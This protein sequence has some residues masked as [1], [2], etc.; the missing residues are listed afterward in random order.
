MRIGKFALLLAAVPYAAAAQQKGPDQQGKAGRT[1]PATAQGEEDEGDDIVV[2]GARNL[3]GAVIGNVEPE[4]QLGPAEIRSFG[5]NSVAELLAALAPQTRSGRGDGAPVVL[6]NGRRV[7]GFS[8]IRDLPTEAILRVDI[9]PEE[10]ALKHGYSADQRVVNFVL[11]PRFRAITA[12]L[13]AQV[14]TDGGRAGPNAEVDLLRINRQGRI[15]L[16]LGYSE[17]SALTESERGVVSAA[18]PFA[19][20]GNV[21][22]LGGQEIDPALSALAGTPATIAGVPALAAS[23]VPTLADFAETAGRANNTDPAPFRTLLPATHNFDANLVYSRTVFSNV[24]ATVNAR[25]STSDSQAQLGLASAA[26]VL[27][28]GNPFSPFGRDVVVERAFSGEFGPLTQRNNQINAHAGATLNGNV[29]KWQ[30][31]LIGN[32]DRN[33]S[34]TFTDTG[35]DLSQFQARL[36]A[37]Y[38]AANP[39]GQVTPADV[40]VN[41]ATLARSTSTNAGVDALVNGTLV[42]LPAGGV[43]VSVRTSASTIGFDSATTRNLV[44]TPASVSRGIVNGQVNVDVPITSRAK[45]VLGAIGSVSANFNY[46]LDHFSDFG[47]LRTL[48]YGLTWVPIVP[49]R[50]LGS[51]T[52]RTGAPSP[53]QLGNPQ[54]TTPNVRVFDFSRGENALV[55]TISGGNPLLEAQRSRTRKLELSVKPWAARDINFVTNYVDVRVDNAIANFPTTTAAIEAAFPDRFVRNAAGQLLRIDV[56]PVNLAQTSRSELRWGINFSAPIKSKIQKQL[57]AFRAGQG[58]N[59]FAGLVPAGGRAPG[60]AGAAGDG[61]PGGGFGGPGGGGFGGR[62][63]AAAA[64]GRVQFAVYHTLRLSELTQ[65]RDTLPRL[66]LLDGDTL[67]GAG[68]PSRHQIEVQTGY[69]NNGIGARISANWESGT[70]VRG[71]TAAVPNDL[72]FGSIGTANFRLFADLGQRLEFVKKHRWARGVRILIAVDNLFNTRQQVTDSSGATPVNFQPAFRDPLG[73]TVRLSFRKLLF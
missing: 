64:G 26:L 19:I 5:V 69:N 39:F 48:G 55:T 45:K 71:G 20:G 59:P 36:S 44:T 23:G 32:Y 21:A 35:L 3:P 29:G 66:D 51:I 6:V 50:L 70:L 17:N 54:I 27:P 56:R 18:S 38:P 72:R 11:R 65:V 31:S 10:V 60:A 42:K 28:Q 7:S 30:W 68:G 40:S 62:G 34:E 24:G 14:A 15:S 13:E 22:G 1:T 12:E 4:N 41:P 16:H 52:E 57:E 2:Q 58:P 49:V 43:S 61:R 25:L 53:Q 73:R 67:G 47:T 8:E 37:N 33:T 46:A 9:L 63:G